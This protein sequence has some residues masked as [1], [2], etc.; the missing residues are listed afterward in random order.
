[1]ADRSQQLVVVFGGG[2][3]I[4]RYVCEYLLKAGVRV[5]V[6]SRNPRSAH[7][8]QPLAQVGRIGFVRADVANADS[9][10]DALEGASAV[11][12]LCGAF[13]RA[14]HDTHV[15]GGGNVA[16]AAARSDRK[17]VV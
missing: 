3:F 5:R 13:G 1:M 4:G 16:Q 17:S 10:A 15:A 11:V 7:F 14:M 8:I 9:M 6:A 2:G 12:N